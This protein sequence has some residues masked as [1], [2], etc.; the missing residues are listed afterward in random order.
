MVYLE[1]IKEA[2]NGIGRLENV[3]VRYSLGR[4]I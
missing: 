4:G 2:N 1:E 3:T